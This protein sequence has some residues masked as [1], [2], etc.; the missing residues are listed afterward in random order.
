M[1]KKKEI[2]FKNKQQKKLYCGIVYQLL[3]I[4]K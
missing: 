3:M 4:Q 1:K 2:L